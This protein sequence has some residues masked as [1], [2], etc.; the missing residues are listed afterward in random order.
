MM[1][2]P[3][4]PVGLVAI[5]G[6]LLL[7]GCSFE[8]ASAAVEGRIQS[9]M[10]NH[11]YQEVPWD[12]FMLEH[13]KEALSPRVLPDITPLALNQHAPNDLLAT[14]QD[15]IAQTADIVNDVDRY[16]NTTRTRQL[17]DPLYRIYGNDVVVDAVVPLLSDIYSKHYHYPEALDVVG[18]GERQTDESHQVVV[19]LDWKIVQD[20]EEF[21]VYPLTFYMDENLT[22]TELE[23]HSPYETP[24]YDR[25]LQADA[26]ISDTMHDDFMEVWQIF[27]ADFNQRETHTTLNADHLSRLV[28]E[29]IPSADLQSLF[30]FVEGDLSRAVLVEWLAHDTHASAE[31]TYTFAVPHYDKETATVSVTFNRSLNE[32]TALAFTH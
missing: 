23:S 2:T 3:L 32:I 9:V 25:P 15:Q 29:D 26:Y 13:D 18:I 6:A 7:S 14:V 8:Q 11:T 28:M 5:G 21:V 17:A 16:V 27:K 31:S 22:V 12:L 24:V 1:G 10:D 19:Q 4:K 20:S 30:T